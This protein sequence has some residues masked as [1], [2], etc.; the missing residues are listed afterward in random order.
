[1]DTK[2]PGVLKEFKDFIIQGDVVML[3]VA[4]VIG[5]AFQAVV[6]A[7]VT[8]ILTPIIG[9]FGKTNFESL[10]FTIHG[11]TF[12]Y[13]DVLNYIITFLAV[14]AAVFF[15]VVKPYNAITARTA[16]NAPADDRA[17]PACL[18]HVPIAATRCSACTSDL[19]PV[20][21]AGA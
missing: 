15:L 1:M 2:A 6:K 11:S 20:E 17:C 9:I 13:G 5:L 3:A 8:D 4:V 19:P 21:P 16:R 18:T 12:L 14:G 10:T 7:F